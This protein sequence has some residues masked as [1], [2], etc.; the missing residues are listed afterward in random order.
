M[1][2][3]FYGLYILSFF[4]LS[5]NQENKTYVG[6]K[7]PLNKELTVLVVQNSEELVDSLYLKL[8]NFIIENSDKKNI[9]DHRY[10][11][12]ITNEIIDFVYSEKGKKLSI[13]QKMDLV[14]LLTLFHRTATYEYTSKVLGKINKKDT[15][16]MSNALYLLPLSN[17]DYCGSKIA[18]AILDIQQIKTPIVYEKYAK[19]VATILN[20]IP[21]ID[22]NDSL[23]NSKRLITSENYKAYTLIPIAKKFFR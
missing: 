21:K 13:K 3:V 12:K 19:N 2:I 20:G 14:L 17:C 22:F 16:V 15:A 23:D 6:T 8:Q 1:K 11:G 4:I 9:T 18:K 5:C 7:K 10:D